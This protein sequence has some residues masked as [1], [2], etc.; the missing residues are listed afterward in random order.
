MNIEIYTNL[1]SF[2]GDKKKLYFVDIGANNGK[3]NSNT[4]YLEEKM[5][6]NGICIEQL[7][8]YFNQLKNRRKSICCKYAV[9]YESNKKMYYSKFDYQEDK[10]INEHL[11][12]H[13]KNKFEGSIEIYTKTLNDILKSYSSP[14][15][16]NYLSINAK[17]KE[18]CILKSV[19]MNKYKF[20]YISI[21]HNYIEPRRKDVRNFLESNGY[22]FI[23]QINY[24]DNYL[25]EDNISGIYYINEDYKVQIEIKRLDKYHFYLLSS[26]W[27]NDICTIN[28]LE[29]YWEKLNLKGKV[30]FNYIDYGNGIIWHKDLRNKK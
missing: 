6:W 16:I 2:Y 26:Y 29:I 1:L 19:N 22:I 9:F 10:N 12:Y 15:I 18:L 24:Y 30:F 11:N 5:D 13:E 7:P 4:Y 14:N 3:F 25:H 28:S 20:L 27:E 8:Y 23:N 17:G 21:E